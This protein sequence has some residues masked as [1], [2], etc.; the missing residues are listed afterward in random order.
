MQLTF[1]AAFTT[2][3][4]TTIY[5]YDETKMDEVFNQF[6][7]DMDKSQSER[8]ALQ[9]DYINDSKNVSKLLYLHFTVI[10]FV[11]FPQGLD[12]GAS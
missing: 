10:Q 11:G 8:E 4:T 9:R 1:G 5:I 6:L 3:G 12:S 7:I 2:A